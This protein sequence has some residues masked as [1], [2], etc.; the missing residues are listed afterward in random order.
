MPR[1]A[2]HG[3]LSLGRI[4]LS[5]EAG[6]YNL[7]IWPLFPHWS[8]FCVRFAIRGSNHR[9][10]FAQ[11]RRITLRF[12]GTSMSSG[13]TFRYAIYGRFIKAPGVFFW[14]DIYSQTQYQI[15]YVVPIPAIINNPTSVLCFTSTGYCD[16]KPM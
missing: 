13:R 14:F 11:S 12:G 3:F 16:R 1:S 9:M 10:I 2:L 4:G 6:Y 5:C 7:S 8:F 15:V